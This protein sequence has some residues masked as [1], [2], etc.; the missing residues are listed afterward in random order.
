M[1]SGPALI[2]CFDTNVLIY[3]FTADDPRHEIASSLVTALA[4]RG[5]PLPAQ[6]LREFLAVAQRK[7][8]I[9]LTS[10]RE[11]VMT[12]DN[13]FDLWAND[14]ADL[15]NASRLA[16]ENR[17]NFYDALMCVVARRSGADILFSEDMQDGAILGGLRIANP[18]AAANRALVAD[19]GS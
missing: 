4:A 14:I 18:F 13:R 8:F 12:F 1:K 7:R 6:V 16:D 11:A 15:V 19:L 9:P 17:L 3:A 10:A 2:V 5:S